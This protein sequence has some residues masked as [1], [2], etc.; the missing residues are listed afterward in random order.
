MPTYVALPPS[1]CV[2]LLS[3]TFNTSSI[4]LSFAAN[5]FKVITVYFDINGGFINTIAMT[6]LTAGTY[7]YEN[8]TGSVATPGASGATAQNSWV[9]AGTSGVTSARLEFNVF[10]AP[11]KK[12]VLF[13]SMSGGSLTVAGAGHSTDTTNDPTAIVITFDATRVGYIYAL[14]YV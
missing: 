1:G 9:P 14:G 8:I 5:Q 6:G 7:Y 3:Q 10:P 13:Q 11:A 12:A 4:T 2:Q